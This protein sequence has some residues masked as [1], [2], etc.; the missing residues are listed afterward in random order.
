MERWDLMLAAKAEQIQRPNEDKAYV[1]KKVSE[2]FGFSS[3]TFLQGIK[4]EVSLY[5]VGVDGLSLALLFV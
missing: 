1:R 2:V 3:I 5:R 4:H